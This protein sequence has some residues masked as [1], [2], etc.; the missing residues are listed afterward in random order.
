SIELYNIG[1]SEYI[2]GLEFSQMPTSLEVVEDE[3]GK[4]RSLLITLPP[5]VPLRL[6][7]QNDVDTTIDLDQDGVPDSIE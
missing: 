3:D 2:G 4:M 1:P 7:G 6:V 5:G